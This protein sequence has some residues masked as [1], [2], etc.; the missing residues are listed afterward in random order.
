[1]APGRISEAA[2]SEGGD[3]TKAHPPLEIRV[4]EPG[5]VKLAS[6]EQLTTALIKALRH[7]DPKL[8][9][10]ALWIFA[11][12]NAVELVTT[13]LLADIA[14]KGRGARNSHNLRKR[15][16]FEEAESTR[17]PGSN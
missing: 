8:A 1:M 17:T 9:E 14:T 4:L 6:E 15:K 10:I 2:A 7:E 11:Y 16:I 3:L 13:E 12:E 5:T